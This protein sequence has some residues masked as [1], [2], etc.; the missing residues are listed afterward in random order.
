MNPKS[1][2]CRV[3]PAVVT[4]YSILAPDCPW[5]GLWPSWNHASPAIEHDATA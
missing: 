4:L 2:L 1:L 3:L 5:L